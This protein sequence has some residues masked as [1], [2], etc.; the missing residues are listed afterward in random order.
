MREK[1]RVAAK[2][3]MF[4]TLVVF[5]GTAKRDDMLPDVL[6]GRPASGVQVEVVA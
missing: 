2:G 6:A 1:R 3:S 4:G 5:G